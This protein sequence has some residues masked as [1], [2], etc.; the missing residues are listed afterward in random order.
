MN[1]DQ[2]I[3]Q[4]QQT[5]KT[6]NVPSGEARN[7]IRKWIIERNEP[8]YEQARLEIEAMATGPQPKTRILT[9]KVAGVTFEGRQE[10]IAL[11]KGN[12][13]VRIQPEPTN[14][15]DPNA[16]AVFV[17]VAPGDVRHVGYLPKE[18]AKEVEGEA[19]MAT[20]IE[21]TGGFAFEDGSIAS[22]GLRIQVEIP[23]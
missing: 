18:L 7:V 23:L 19:V 14:P 6:R 17:A 12:E 5:A 22:Y 2:M 8:N 15:Y 3:D 4:L 16:L 9:C 21:K 20:L 10:T 13:P 1:K 11:L